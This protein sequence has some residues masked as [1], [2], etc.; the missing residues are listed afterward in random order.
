MFSVG[1]ILRLRKLPH[2]YGL[3]KKRG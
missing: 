1:L 2:S 3:A